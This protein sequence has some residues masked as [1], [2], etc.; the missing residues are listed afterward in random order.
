MENSDDRSSSPIVGTPPGGTPAANRTTRHRAQNARGRIL[1]VDDE[2]NARAALSEILHEE[3]YATETA[4][5]GFKALGK[6]EEFAPDVILTDLKMPGLDGITFMDKARAAAPGAV[7]VV[8]TAFGTI[9]SAVAAVKKGADN[10]LTKPL[11]FESLSAIVERAMEKARLLQEAR[12]LRDRL[13][14][15]NAF[16]LIV[17]DDAK[18]HEIL[19]LVAQVGPSRASVLIMGESG[20]GKELIAESIHA[21]SPR[22]QKPFVRLNCAALAESLLESE[23]FGHERGA[24]TGAVG[25][26]DGRFKQADGGTLFLDEIGEIPLGTQVKLLRFLQERTFERV[27]GN[28]TLKVDVRVICATNRDLQEEIK[29][30]RFREDLF[31]RL[32]VVTIN[33]PP[34]RDRRS[35]IPALASFFLRRYAAENGRNIEGISDEALERL[36]SYAW[37]GNVRELENAVERAVVLCEGTQ[38]EARHL[39]PTLVPQTQREGAPPI[40]GSTIADLERYAILKTLEA[41]GGSTSKAAML[42]GVSTRK[43]QYKLHEY[44]TTGA[45]GL[46]NATP[47]STRRERD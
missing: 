21:A 47:A 30:G 19:E 15:R 31:Y 28:E 29:K 27:G 20:T 25:R 32:N 45:L 14:E 23:L 5:D 34:L 39:P 17:S 1:I 13:R 2:A 16:G 18:M 26:R 35:D 44:G 38:I 3:G 7:F 12:Q 10:Y 11:E 8:M 43:I 46:P 4:A 36:A 40:P 33:L 24:F 37:P 9:S 22:V 42:L 41:C 6:L